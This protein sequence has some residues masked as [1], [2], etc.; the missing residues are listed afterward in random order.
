MTGNAKGRPSHGNDGDAA[1][2]RSVAAGDEHRSGNRAAYW[3]RRIARSQHALRV[4]FAASF[5][6]TIIVP[7]PIELVLIPFMAMN[8]DRLWRTA[9]V[10]TAGC[11]AASFVGYAIGYAFFDTV[12]NDM[13]AAFGWSEALDRFR[14]LFDRHGFW[15]IIAVGVIPIPF[16]IAML[17]AGA[18][19]YPIAMFALAA[20]IA[21]GIRYY[22]LALLVH[23]VGD[24]AEALWRT[25]RRTAIAIGAAI[26]LAVFA[27]SLLL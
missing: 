3:T 22:G 14:S 17:A 12:G 25:N 4:L 13:V 2:L 1:A 24:R 6:E 19:G 5:A 20:L 27:A 21:R 26:L 10:V 15:A 8:R 16:Q 18:A 9:T 7:I 23:A 11:L